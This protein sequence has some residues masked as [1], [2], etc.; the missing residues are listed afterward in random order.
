MIP[1]CTPATE[2]R[3]TPSRGIPVRAQILLAA[4]GCAGL[5]TF[6]YAVDP[7]QHAFYP[8]CWLYNTTGIYCA[9]CGVTRAAYALLH[10][11]LLDALHDNALFVTT[12]PLILFVAG[13]Y[14]LAAWRSRSWP[15]MNADPRSVTK[16]GVAAMLLM[17]AF[18]AIRNLPGWPFSYLRPLSS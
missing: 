18:M 9:G 16:W 13:S 11:R 2:S 4:C 12:L 14:T 1:V 10:G 15:A 3:S 5:S 6:L 17:I 8:Q 7:T